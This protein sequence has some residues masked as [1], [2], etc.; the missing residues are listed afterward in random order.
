MRF[1]APSCCLT[2]FLFLFS[3]IHATAQIRDED[4]DEFSS[5]EF[6]EIQIV[7]SGSQNFW[8]TKLTESIPEI[9][10]A[11][12]HEGDMP[13]L[14]SILESLKSK[15]C[16]CADVGSCRQMFSEIMDENMEEY[17]RTVESDIGAG[18]DSYCCQEYQT[19][20]GQLYRSGGS[21]NMSIMEQLLDNNCHPLATLVDDF[22]AN[23][24]L[25]GV[26]IVLPIAFSISNETYRVYAVVFLV[27]FIFVLCIKTL[28]IFGLVWTFTSRLCNQCFHGFSNTTA[29]D[30]GIPLMLNEDGGP[31]LLI[32]AV[33]N[34][35][36]PENE[37]NRDREY[38]GSSS[39]ECESREPGGFHFNEIS[40]VSWHGGSDLP[41]F[42]GSNDNGSF[43][44]ATAAPT[45]V[46]QDHHWQQDEEV[47]GVRTSVI[48]ISY[49]GQ[50]GRVT[51]NDGQSKASTRS[52]IDSMHGGMY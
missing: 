17:C 52:D 38:V 32:Y 41:V 48:P 12:Q 15:F 35:I 11:S 13:P 50:A 1:W 46:A 36:D 10:L 24:T 16:C 7:G 34:E 33:E 18:D 44:A 3:N 29:N 39:S 40:A 37:E 2:V 22:G 25:P 23:V 30:A 9:R 42:E 45:I 19:E 14:S 20:L 43:Q 21:F 27:I 28:S 51:L 49:G 31:V 4:E 8:P 6:L 5:I 47:P 26:W